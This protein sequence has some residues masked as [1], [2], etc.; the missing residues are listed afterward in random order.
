[1]GS[2]FFYVYSSQPNPIRSDPG[3]TVFPKIYVSTN[4]D[5]GHVTKRSVTALGHSLTNVVASHF[6]KIRE[7]TITELFSVVL[8]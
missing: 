1:M 7:A 2:G 6:G 3:S 4:E 5:N 8:R